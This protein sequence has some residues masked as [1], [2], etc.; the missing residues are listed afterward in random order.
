VVVIPACCDEG[1]F[2]PVA[3]HQF[4]AEHAAVESE[5]PLKVG[6]FQVN[7]PDPHARIGRL[8]RLT[9]AHH[10]PQGF[11]RHRDLLSR[12]ARLSAPRHSRTQSYIPPNPPD[13][14]RKCA[15]SGP[16][17]RTFEPQGS[18]LGRNTFRVPVEQGEIEVASDQ[19]SVLVRQALRHSFQVGRET[20]KHAA[21]PLCG[22]HGCVLLETRRQWADLSP[23]RHKPDLKI[24][25]Q[26]R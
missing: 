14:L 23:R 9:L 10:G 19:L 11:E 5:R 25:V 8:L 18:I 17:Q 26:H 22:L 13:P 16:V 12:A 15:R 21:S 4:K 6:H 7:V 2:G 1:G 24:T 3:L 20:V